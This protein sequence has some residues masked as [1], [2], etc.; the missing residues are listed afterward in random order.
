[1]DKCKQIT[2]PEAPEV[3]LGSISRQLDPGRRSFRNFDMLEMLDVSIVL[4]FFRGQVPLCAYD[5]FVPHGAVGEADTTSNILRRIGYY[6]YSAIAATRNT[7]L[8][9]R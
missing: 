2:A 5:I 7:P 3:L 8:I 9:D 4:C 6:I 1:D